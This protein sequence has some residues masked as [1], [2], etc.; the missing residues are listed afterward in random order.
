MFQLV[1]AG[2]ANPG[3]LDAHITG[4]AGQLAGIAGG[5]QV[6]GSG[7]IP[8]GLPLEVFA[9]AW[10]WLADGCDGPVAADQLSGPRY[11]IDTWA[12]EDPTGQIILQRHYPG[13]DSQQGCGDS[14]YDVTW[15]IQHYRG[16]WEVTDDSGGSASPLMS[17]TGIGAATHHGAVHAF[18]VLS[19]AEVTHA[20]TFTGASWYVDSVGTFSLADL[21]VSAVSFDGRLYAVGVLAD[22]TISP[23][24][25]TRDGSSW[26][27]TSGGFSGQYALQPIA[28]LY[29]VQP[30]AT[31]VSR[32]QMYVFARDAQSAALRV[33]STSD[34]RSWAPWADVPAAGLPPS[35]AVAAAALGGTIC[36]FGIYQT[37]KPPETAVVVENTSSDGGITWSGW[38]MVEEGLRP[39][40]SP[41]TDEPLDVAAAVFRDRVHIATRWRYFDGTGGSHFYMAVNFSGDV[42]DWSGWRRPEAPEDDADYAAGATAGLAA[43]GNHLYII[44]P[45]S[46]TAAPG[47]LPVFAY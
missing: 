17:G 29:T 28:G 3:T 21:P 42:A 46:G 47:A 26:T 41:A 24:A 30:I 25:F 36:L 22:S 4:T 13:A 38:D 23:L 39:E 6:A 45:Q 12:D 7:P 31:T 11:V 18:G 32:D 9:D 10:P 19:G 37:G 35:S 8:V 16:W 1:N 43:V 5:A 27:L 2:H 40:G 34:L 15:L 33:T 44:A 20:R 14:S